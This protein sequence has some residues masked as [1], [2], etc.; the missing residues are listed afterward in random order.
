[1]HQP[2]GWKKVQ[3][4]LFKKIRI[5]G[6]NAASYE[7]LWGIELSRISLLFLTLFFCLV[8]FFL[9]YL[10]LGYTPLK[11]LLPDSALE[12]EKG[13][14]EKQYLKIQALEK[15]IDLQ[16][17]YIDDFK[18]V[19]LGKPIPTDKATP[20]S[21]KGLT[22]EQVK[23]SG[24]ESPNEKQFTQKVEKDIRENTS[25]DKAEQSAKGVFFF[26][27]VVGVI[28]GKYTKNHPGIDV[29][30]RENTPIKSVFN[31]T[32]I[33]SDWTQ[34]NGYTIII[35]H[36]NHFLSIYKHNSLLLKKQ[37]DIVKSGDPIAIIGNTGEN[38]TG[39]HLH[40][41]LFFEGK[42]VNPLDF[43]SFQ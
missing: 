20:I 43:I 34:E 41:E 31:G 12:K 6:L 22:N 28:S 42:N 36:P 39:S 24:K 40:F 29:V 10:T 8:L 35:Y 15:K 11:N 17:R 19:I 27:P 13:S 1:M 23:L 5:N 14:I 37:G 7:R 25:I 30:A 9:S 2:K 4:Y 3:L 32:I 33:F 16:T 18:N 38:T 26:T 21:K